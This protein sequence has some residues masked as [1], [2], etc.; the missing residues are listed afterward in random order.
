[1]ENIN[2]N[3]YEQGFL[4]E[5][6]IKQGFM[7]NDKFFELGSL[8]LNNLMIIEGKKADK[9]SLFGIISNISTENVDNLINK[10]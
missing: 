5:K 6:N 7:F 4:N 1:M 2:F 8:E 3:E 10:N 9:D